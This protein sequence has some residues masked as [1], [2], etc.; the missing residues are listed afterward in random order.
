MRRIFSN[1]RRNCRGCNIY[2]HSC[3]REEVHDIFDPHSRFIPQDF[4]DVSTF[5]KSI[6]RRKPMKKTFIIIIA[7]IALSSIC[8]ASEVVT[9]KDG[10]KVLLKDDK[11]WEYVNDNTESS[12]EQKQ[13]E[14]FTEEKARSII[15]VSRVFTTPPNSAGGVDLHITWQNKSDKPVKYAYFEVEPYNRVGDP[16]SCT[17]KRYSTFRGSVTGPIAPGKTWSGYWERTW[18]NNTI[19]KAKLL[20]V[21]IEYMDGS[22]VEFKEKEVDYILYK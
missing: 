19:V 12:T 16:V 11:T 18:Y 9:T 22:K 2:H 14:Q 6:L 20:L 21:E 17:I 4:T 7:I 8:L 15:K 5:A 3:T 1:I 13:G 10:K